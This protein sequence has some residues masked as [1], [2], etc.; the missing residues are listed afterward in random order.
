MFGALIGVAVLY[1]RRRAAARHLTGLLAASHAT[2]ERQVEERTAH[3]AAANAEL[4]HFAYAASHDLQEPL[5]NVTRFLQL[6]SRRY[7]GK[8]DAEADEYIDYAV[9]GAKQMS[10][11][12][13]DVLA[14]SKAG[15]V[16]SRPEAVESSRMVRAAIELLDSSIIEAGATIDIDALPRVY[17]QPAQLQ[18]LFQNLIGNAVKFRSADQAPHI[19]V[20]SRPADAPGMAE[21]AVADNGI[22]IETQYHD[23]IFGLFQRLHSRDHYD[24]T[25]IGLALCRKI[26]ERCGGRIWAESEV[27]RGTIIRF[28]LPVA[29]DLN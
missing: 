6:L 21:F 26:V 5:R 12:I 28:T 22:G 3:L 18:S 29:D 1:D 8:L 16:D 9:K 14:Y 23:R 15:G 17:C 19:V 4:Q 2:L 27:G 25:G 11:L 20:S 10:A 7:R 24:G 13:N